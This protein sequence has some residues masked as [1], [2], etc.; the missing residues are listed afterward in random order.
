MFLVVPDI[1]GHTA[2]MVH[3]ELCIQKYP[4]TTESGSVSSLL[5]IVRELSGGMQRKKGT[6]L[7]CGWIWQT[8]IDA[9]VLS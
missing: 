5:K 6:Q 1:V 2:P 3:Q 4:I 8:R 9:N 7:Y